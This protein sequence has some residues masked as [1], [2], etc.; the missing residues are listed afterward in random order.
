MA[1]KPKRFEFDA[2]IEEGRGGG[3]W[4]SVPFD[5]REEFGTGGQVRVKASF[6]GEPYRRSIA[7]MGGGNHILGI[8]KEIRERL[9]KG[10][11]DCVRVVLV[12][13]T[14]ERTIEVPPELAAAFKRQPK[15]RKKFDTLS[16]TRRREAAESVA[17]AKKDETKQRRVAKTIEQLLEG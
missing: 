8:R 5:V 7:P 3:A 2:A 4:I 1:R 11:G 12:E 14:E 10:I 13:D 15:A 6:D 16:Y 9:G 17:G